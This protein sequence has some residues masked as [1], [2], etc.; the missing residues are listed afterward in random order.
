MTTRF[1]PFFNF[2]PVW[3]YKSCSFQLRARSKVISYKFENI[4]LSHLVLLHLEY[5]KHLK[6]A[7]I[8]KLFAFSI[9]W[10]GRGI[11]FRRKIS[12]KWTWLLYV[13]IYTF[14]VFFLSNYSFHICIQICLN[15]FLSSG[16]NWEGS[17]ITFQKPKTQFY[18]ERGLWVPFMSYCIF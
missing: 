2:L 4:F 3:S 10:G 12:V 13:K 15:I 18:G 17:N 16:K 6:Y 7:N 14:P 5:L 1:S 9:I 11:G 8:G